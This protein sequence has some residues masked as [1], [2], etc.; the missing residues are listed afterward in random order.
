M[1]ARVSLAQLGG[2]HHIAVAG[3]HIEQ[4]GQRPLLIHQQ[5][6]LKFTMGV[7]SLKQVCTSSKFAR[8]VRT[9]QLVGQLESIMF[10]LCLCLMDSRRVLNLLLEETFQTDMQTDKLTDKVRY[11]SSL[12]DFNNF[13]LDP[14]SLKT[15]PSCKPGRGLIHLLQVFHQI[16][17]GNLKKLVSFI[18]L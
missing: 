9:S 17:L 13:F 4:P 1:A 18:L 2:H 14:H 11:R 10:I 3:R 15:L 16:D 5:V 12:P 8:Q 6:V 7:Q